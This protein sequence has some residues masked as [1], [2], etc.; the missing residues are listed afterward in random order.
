MKIKKEREK[1]ELKLFIE[2]TII[3]KLVSLSVL[4]RLMRGCFKGNLWPV[5]ME[6]GRKERGVEGSRVV[7]VKNKLITCLD[8]RGVKRSIVEG[9]RVG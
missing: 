2:Q 3:Q 9:E 1:K 8:V 4:L 7:L 5:W 6:G